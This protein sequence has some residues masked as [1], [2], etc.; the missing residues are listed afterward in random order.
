MSQEYPGGFSEGGPRIISWIEKINF[1]RDIVYNEDEDF[2]EKESV[3]KL[4]FRFKNYE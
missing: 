1:T 4:E 2:T 3:V